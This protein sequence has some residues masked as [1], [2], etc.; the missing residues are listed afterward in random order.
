MSI[1][2]FPYEESKRMKEELFTSSS[3]YDKELFKKSYEEFMRIT[4]QK[5]DT[6]LPKFAIVEDKNI[7]LEITSS[8]NYLKL[9]K[10]LRL[11]N[12]NQKDLQ[13]ATNEKEYTMLIQTHQHLQQ[14]EADL[15]KMVG[16]VII[17]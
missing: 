5:R 14:I 13:Q 16:S 7:R 4:T 6:E 1:T 12:Q 10:V 3:G 17:R 11:I 2:N 8:L 15:Q 9:K